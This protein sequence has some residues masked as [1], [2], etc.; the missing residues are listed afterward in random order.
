MTVK[1]GMT[2]TVITATLLPERSALLAEA[3]ASVAAQ[4]QRPRDH[5]IGA[6]YLRRGGA[7]VYNI[8][9][10]AATTPWLATLPD[11]DA[12]LPGHLE[13]L[14]A[15]AGDADV[16]YSPPET[17]G[18]DPWQGYEQPFAPDALRRASIVS[19][20]ALVR[21]ELVLDLGG[22]DE[23]QGYDW[24]FWVKALDAGA[25]FVR[26]PERTWRYRLDAGM[27]H[28]SRPWLGAA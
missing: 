11:D 17:S 4:T 13:T 9:A 2:V 19:H 15:A 12:F 26:V 21:T 1:V 14:L 7:R 6:D 27:W 20:V 10:S 22:W 5:L 24:R 18:P 8:L 25:R 16:V 23:G 3:C 28:E